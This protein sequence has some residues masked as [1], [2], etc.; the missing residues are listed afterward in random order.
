MFII[1]HASKL[2]FHNKGRIILYET[3]Q[4]AESFLDMFI[5]YSTSRLA[6][7]GKLSA[8]M[9]TGIIIMN[10]CEIKPA[11]FDIENVKCG[12]VWMKELFDKR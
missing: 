3:R 11:G 5:Q 10:E 1:Q 6:Q 8:A 12:V 2:Y 7:M 4:E 9:Q